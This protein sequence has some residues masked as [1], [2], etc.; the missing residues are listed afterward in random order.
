MIKTVERDSSLTMWEKD[1]QLPAN[2]RIESDAIPFKHSS[3]PQHIFLTGLTGLLGAFLSSELLKGTKATLYPL[4]RPLSSSPEMARVKNNLLKYGLWKDEYEKRIIPVAGDLTKRR[5]GI[6][7]GLYTEL[8]KRIDLIYHCGAEV[9]HIFPY[10]F[11]KATNVVGTLSIIEFAGC[12]KIKPIHFISSDAACL[13]KSENGDPFFHQ[14]ETLLEDGKALLGG[15]AQT[16]WVSEHHLSQA[17][18]MGLPYTIFRCGQITGSSEKV[19]GIANDLFHSYFKIFNEAGVVPQWDDAV[20]DMVPIDFVSRV[21]SSVTLQESCYGKIFHLTNPEPPP[22]NSL[23]DYLLKRGYAIERVGFEE[24]VESCF[25]Y[26]FN[27]PN[28]ERKAVLL[29]FFSK[30]SGGNF[31]FEYYFR[32]AG[33]RHDNLKEELD[34]LEIDFPTID[35]QWWDKGMREINRGINFQ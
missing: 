13:Q 20:L 10:H 25:Y 3:S 30:D 18:A 1:R 29:E 27:L 19:L 28:S 17:G 14:S 23:F 12:K 31:L 4:I 21:L 5:L 32:K 26:I 16:K 34:R 24:W 22:I 35:E 2:I 6:E 33:F 9:N 7:P 8:S 15:Y 11:L